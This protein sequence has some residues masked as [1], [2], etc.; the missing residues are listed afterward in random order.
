MSVLLSMITKL[1]WFYRIHA[2]L[3][4][5]SKHL[6]QKSTLTALDFGMDCSPEG[7]EIEVEEEGGQTT[8]SAVQGAQGEMQAQ[9]SSAGEEGG[10]K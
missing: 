10:G 5:P 1:T 6:P 2:K 4:P 7:R 9:E 8:N 3:D